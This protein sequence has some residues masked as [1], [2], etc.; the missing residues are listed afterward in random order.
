MT[1]PADNQK[2]NDAEVAS[3]REVALLPPQ[4]SSALALDATTAAWPV[5]TNRSTAGE[6]ELSDE[7]LVAAI[8]RGDHGLGKQLYGRLIRVVDATLTR[9]LGPGQAEHDD[10]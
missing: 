5:A 4:V 9:I 1:A 8:Q 10:L 7:A 2:Q 6:V 3:S